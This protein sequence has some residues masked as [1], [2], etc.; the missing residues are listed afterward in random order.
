MANTI[1]NLNNAINVLTTNQNDSSLRFH[2]E[3]KAG[4]GY[5]PLQSRITYE[6]EL[7]DTH[8]AMN[9]ETG[10][11]TAPFAGTFGFVFYAKFLTDYDQHQ[12]YVDHNQ[13]RIAIFGYHI[14][15]SSEYGSTSAY[16]ALS[17]KKDDTVGIY[18]G[19]AKIGF[20]SYPA[21]F[22][23]FLLQKS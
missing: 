17:L 10:I 12:L 1:E 16:F 21:K 19:T 11:F 15:S 20:Y 22:T 23:G 6:T 4:S 8:N 14:D 3:T 18:T 7:T 13:A 9:K 5:L 2:V